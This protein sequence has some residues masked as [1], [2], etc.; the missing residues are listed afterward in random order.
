MV[1]QMLEANPTLTPAQVKQLLIDTAEPLDDVPLEK[2]GAGVVN[3][4]AA[5]EAALKRKRRKKS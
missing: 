1:A 4:G 2:Q 5:V 3:A